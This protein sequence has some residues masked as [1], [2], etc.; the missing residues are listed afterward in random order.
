[1]TGLSLG[2]GPDDQRFDAV[3]F[4]NASDFFGG[5]NNPRGVAHGSILTGHRPQC[6]EPHGQA[7]RRLDSL[8]D[9]HATHT[10]DLGLPRGVMTGAR[11]KWRKRLLR[12]HFLIVREKSP[13]FQGHAAGKLRVKGKDYVMRAGDICHFLVNR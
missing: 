2:H 9:R 6:R 8:F 3:R 12:A 11:S 7:Q 10:S 4:E 5:P 1:L 13:V